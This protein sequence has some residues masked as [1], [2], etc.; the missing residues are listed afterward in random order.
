MAR[1]TGTAHHSAAVIMEDLMGVWRSRTLV[2]AVE[3]DVF[4]QIAKRKR[5][6]KEIAEAAGASPRGMAR[7]LDALSAIG[8]LRKTGNRY[9]LHPVSAAFLVPGKE[10]YIGAM[11]ESVSLTWDSWKNLTEAVRSGRP[12]E[13]MNVAEK[14]KAF[15]LKLVTGL[16]P[17]NFAASVA[18]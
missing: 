1:K 4:S 9:G 8:Y 3:L 17:G 12:A 11:T 14:G 13:A 18:G 7:L 6:V 2:A 16:F 5:T 15:F 10:A